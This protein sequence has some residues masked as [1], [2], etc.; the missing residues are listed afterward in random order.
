MAGFSTDDLCQNPLD[1]WPWFGTYRA[2]QAFVL[3]NWQ[4]KFK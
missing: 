1:D 4:G 3:A 2:N